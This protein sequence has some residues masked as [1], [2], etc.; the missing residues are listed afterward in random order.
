[1]KICNHEIHSPKEKPIDHNKHPIIVFLK[2]YSLIWN[3]E[4]Q[5]WD[6]KKNGKYLSEKEKIKIICLHSCWCK[7][8]F[9]AKENPTLYEEKIIQKDLINFQNKHKKCGVKIKNHNITSNFILKE[10]SE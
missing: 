6:I 8:S 4:K 9:W 2:D 3:K 5:D 7:A 1:M 10:T